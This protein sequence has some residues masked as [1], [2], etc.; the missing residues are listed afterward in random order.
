MTLQPRIDREAAS[1]RVHRGDVLGVVD[2]L[3]AELVPAI[4]VAVVHVLTDDRVRT[5][6]SIGVDLGH[7]HV[8]QEVDQ[9]L[10]ARGAV[11]LP[12]LLLQRLLQDLLSHLCTV[13]E[14]EGDTG[15]EVLLIKV[16]QGLVQHEGF[17]GAS[18]PDQHEGELA[19]DQKIDEELHPDRLRIVDKTR[20]KRNIRVQVKLG[21][22]VNS[23]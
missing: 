4:P 9:L 7:V 11:V 2:L 12:R 8:V 19:L 10:A 6:G 17:S 13:V 21:N 5:H 23:R 20:L 14:V 16:A 3:Q 18:Q 15:N 1:G 22:P